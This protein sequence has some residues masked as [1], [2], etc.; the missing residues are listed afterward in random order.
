MFSRFWD[1]RTA[2][3]LCTGL[4]F[5]A[6]IA[7]LRAASETLTLFLFAILFAYFVEPLVA[8][9]ERR[10]HGRVKSIA[11]VYF[12][13]FGALVGLGFLIGPRIAQEGKSLITT[14]P[15]L[16]DRLASGQLIHQVGTHQGWTA[17]RQ[18]QVEQFFLAHRAQ[19]LGH[20][21]AGLAS[22]AGPLSHV[23]WLILIPILGFFFLKDASALALSLIQVGRTH[24]YRV[25][26][27]GIVAD[28]NLMLGSYIRAQLILAAL[29]AAALTLVLSLMRAP[30]SFALGPL[31]GACEFIPV[32]GPAVACCVIWGIAALTGYPHL[33]WL[34]LFLGTWRVIQDYINAPRIMG[35]S[36]QMSPLVEIFG[37]LAGGEI[38]GVVGALVSVPVIAILR[39][40]WHRLGN[41][42]PATPAAARLPLSTAPAPDRPLVEQQHAP[43]VAS[44]HHPEPALTGDRT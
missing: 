10:I 26:M 35:G 44:S 5:V 19:I 38:G 21:Q 13:L 3:I 30:Y 14:L 16:F 23:W 17:D 36:L 22:L 24:D 25:V 39:I 43:A 18:Q 15:A 31:A 2:R 20:V 11:I 29:T 8:R 6:V 1:A 41:R 33:V 28:V 7:F 27:D 9:C 37:V 34:F 12:V 4:I 40:L 32:V 42:D